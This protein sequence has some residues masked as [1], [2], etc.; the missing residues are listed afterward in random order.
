MVDLITVYDSWNLEE[1]ALPPRSHLY[2]LEPIG[3]GTPYVES[4]TG[5]VAR[6]SKTH[7]V[8]TGMLIL[9]QIAPFMK[10]G[11]VFN[12]RAGGI[13]KVYGRYTRAFNGASNWTNAL[14]TALESLTL[15]RDLRFLSMLPWAEVIPL[16][17]LLRSNR[18]WCPV[19]YEDWAKTE[20]EIYEPLLWVFDS[21]KICSYH[22]LP[23]C[24]KCP[25]CHKENRQLDW[26][27]SPGY[28]SKC[29]EWLGVSQNSY[30]TNMGELVES[31]LS[32][33]LWAFENI[34]NLI[35]T[36][37]SLVNPPSKETIS[38]AIAAYVKATSKGTV[39]QFANRVGIGGQQIHRHIEGKTLPSL[40]TLLQLCGHLGVPLLNFLT[41]EPTVEDLTRASAHLP[42]LENSVRRKQF[43]IRHNSASVQIALE[44]ALLES[45][46]PS[47]KELGER[48][49]YASSGPLYYHASNLA[50]ALA[51]KH[52]AYESAQRLEKMQ[53]ILKRTLQNDEYPPPSM[54]DVAKREG[55][56]VQLL[57]STFPELS[58]A[59]S[60]RYK[61]YQQMCKAT[62]IEKLRQEVR[63]AALQL[64]KQGTKPTG[65]RVSKYLSK[66]GS[67]LQQPA[68]EALQEIQHE[69]GWKS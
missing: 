46:P 19:C 14:V 10:E 33:Q 27:S 68:I 65:A 40:K 61:T 2:Y 18:A 39:S 51:E 63:E 7:Y 31:N 47:V 53:N 41:K 37:P 45:P 49:G 64:H 17:Y 48:L 29:K 58:K 21:I 57:T 26:Y 60:D 24:T 28:C 32:W 13:D 34:G 50:H 5:Y 56:G 38:T 6:L 1:P 59:I 43:E 35:A 16:R 22:S 62:R 66:P 69:L 8:E 20:Q 4:L 23:L 44:K 9:T 42:R 15:R 30:Q 12:G 3:L 54:Q 55:L 36:A 67:I 25:H 11:Y 52:A